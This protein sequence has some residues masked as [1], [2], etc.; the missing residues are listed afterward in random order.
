MICEEGIPSTS[1]NHLNRDPGI[2]LCLFIL[3]M[4]ETFF[5]QNIDIPLKMWYDK[6]CMESK[7]LDGNYGIIEPFRSIQH[8]KSQLQEDQTE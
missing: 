4:D 3:L 1:L 6:I 8:Q 2:L 5:I 7:R